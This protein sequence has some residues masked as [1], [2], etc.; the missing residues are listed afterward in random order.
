MSFLVEWVYDAA[1]SLPLLDYLLVLVI[2]VIVAAV[3]FL[4]G[5]IVGTIFAVILFVVNY[6]RVQII[7]DVLTGKTYQSRKER[8]IEHRQLLEDTGGGILILRLQGYLFFGTAQGLL[9]RFRDRIHDPKEERLRFLIL[10][11]QH[12]SALDTSAV[13]SFTRMYQLC[14][15]NRSTV[16]TALS[17]KIGNF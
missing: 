16:A 9:N 15:T 14:E 4:E 8:P 13:V 5:V 3:G 6:S 7:K 10:D 12:V 2:L 17:P 11:F 1:R